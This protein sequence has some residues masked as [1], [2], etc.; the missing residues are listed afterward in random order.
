MSLM[1]DTFC[2][3]FT[4]AWQNKR[5]AYGNPRGQAFVHVVHSRV[6]EYEFRCTY[7]YHKKKSPYR[8]FQV[9]VLHNDGIIVV[10]NP[11]TDINFKLQSGIFVT[12][13]RVQVGHTLH[14]SEAYLG[15]NHY[16]VVDQGFDVNN[17]SQLWGLEPGCMYEFDRS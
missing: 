11:V 9:K 15:P 3:W 4:G 12:D 17:G 8:D 5:Q 16:H 14:I 1:L 7:T 2:T 10:K 6:S 13:S